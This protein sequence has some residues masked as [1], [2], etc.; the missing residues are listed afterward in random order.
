ML[1][2]EDDQIYSSEGDGEDLINQDM[3]KDYQPVA[4]L[5]WYEN[6]GIDNEE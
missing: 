2:D 3:H 5:D 4:E 1:N 6:V